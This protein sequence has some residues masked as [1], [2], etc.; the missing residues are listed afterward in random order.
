[1]KCSRGARIAAT[2]AR[3]VAAKMAHASM[4]THFQPIRF[5]PLRTT[6]NTQSMITIVQLTRLLRPPQCG[7]LP[8]SHT[9]SMGCSHEPT[10]QLTITALV[11]SWACF[12]A[13]RALSCK[14]SLFADFM[15]MLQ[16]I[17]NAS[18]CHYL[19][20]YTIWLYCA[21]GLLRESFNTGLASFSSLFQCHVMCF[22]R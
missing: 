4:G 13:V 16:R 9:F 19:L 21:A 6:K 11:S 17:T 5:M 14:P 15:S 22:Y 18:W 10:G 12:S 3:R 20:K 7:S 2:T 1:M 8:S